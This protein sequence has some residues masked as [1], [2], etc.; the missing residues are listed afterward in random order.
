MAAILRTGSFTHAADNSSSNNNKIVNQ[1]NPRLDLTYFVWHSPAIVYWKIINNNKGKTKTKKKSQLGK[2][3]TTWNDRSLILTQINSKK[4]KKG[5]NFR[6]KRRRRRIRPILHLF[7]TSRKKKKKT[8]VTESRAVAPVMLNIW[9]GSIT[10][11]V[12]HE[13]LV[14]PPTFFFVLLAPHD[15]SSLLFHDWFS[16]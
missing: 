6:K 1:T 7:S 12:K 9:L 8:I 13:T 11:E 16:L 5:K 4:K 3:E 2:R 14:N 10:N 15:P